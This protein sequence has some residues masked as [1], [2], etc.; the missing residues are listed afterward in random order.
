MREWNLRAGDPLTLTLA[1]DARLGPTDYCDDQIWTLSLGE[2]EPPALAL[3]TTYGL[4]AR[5]LRLFPR[6]TEGDESVINPA[7]FAQPP[8]VRHFFPNYLQVHF[9]PLPSIDVTAEYWV[10][11]SK[12]IA[13]RLR[14]ANRGPLPRALRVEWIAQLTPNQG[15]R[16]A[17]TEIQAAPVLA[18]TSD[19]LAPV[20]FVTGGPLAGTGSYPALRLDLELPPGGEHRLTWSQA[21]LADPEASFRLARGLAARPWEA[22]IARMELVDSGLVDIRTGDPDW[23]AAFA[24]AQKCAFGLFLGAT[25]HLPAPSFVFSRQPDQGYSLCGDGS[26]YNHLWNGQS[27]FEAYYLS[28][29][30]LPGAPELAKGLV[31]NF[32]SAQGEDGGLDWK[33][34]LGGQRSRLLATPLI[35][36]LAWKIYTH[37]TDRAFLAEVYPGLWRAVQAWFSPSQDRDGDG[38]PEW[39]H[40]L[41]TGFDDHPVFS[42]WHTWSQQAD[43]HTAEGPALCALLYRECRSLLA[44]AACLER[45]EAVT[46]VQSLAEHLAAAVEASWDEEQATYRKW[47]RD[48]HVC[49]AGELL[50]ERA[51]PGVLSI[52]RAFEQ[53]VRLLV[54]IVS[55]GEATRQPQ[56][57][58]YGESAS[59]QPRVETITKERFHWTMGVGVLTGERVFSRL[60]TLEFSGLEPGD[61]ITLSSVDFRF[62][63]QTALLPLWAGIP[64]PERAEALVRRTVLAPELFWRPFG[65]RACPQPATGVPEEVAGICRNVYLPWNALI[66]EGLLHYGYAQETADLF[67]RLIVPAIRSLKASQAFRSLYDA[68]SGQASGEWNAL[69]GLVP[70]G[71]FLD[72]LGVRLISPFKVELRGYNPFPWPVTVKYRGMTIL[73]QKDMGM[74]I[75]PDGQ[76]VR[77]ED[78]APRLISLE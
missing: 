14:I 58:I 29:L 71:L 43:I 30:I 60:E 68:E 4:R 61:R 15:Q 5:S 34:G 40:T 17:A 57:V 25:P 46:A 38:I 16:M 75:F 13:G 44:M 59:G 22:E 55:D 69:Q 63:D 26:D 52:Q 54:R 37:T 31:R 9:S 76:T 72:I 64:T 24:L 10:P 8:A 1:A 21:A 2:G 66:G 67:S 51:G 28:G 53:P 12:G 47:D 74:V 42:R 65:I 6:F 36:T 39:S 41:Q 62:L 20:V 27:P 23:D 48:T 49:T 18:G 45:P 11:D 77:V 19:S 3:Q 50:G 78:P 7:Q 32:L 33:P 73:R 35:A 70:M 56:V